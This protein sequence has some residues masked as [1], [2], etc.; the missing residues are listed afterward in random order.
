MTYEIYRLIFIG[1]A[2]LCGIMFIVSIL[3]FIFLHVPKLI[4]DLSG[5]AA[6]KAIENIREQNEKSGDKPHKTNTVNRKR[7]RLTDKISPSGSLPRHTAKMLDTGMI[8][9]KISPQGFATG[10]GTNIL[11]NDNET[12][13]LGQTNETVFGT[14]TNETTVLGCGQRPINDSVV[15]SADIDIT[16]RIEYEIT[17]LHSDELVS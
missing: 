2:V 8:T 13:V 3:L 5:V 10:D 4:G 17:F 16:F 7:G 1:A 9:E 11:E 15:G 14:D 12:M 6:R